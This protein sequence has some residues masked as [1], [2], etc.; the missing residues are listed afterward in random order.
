[1]PDGLI[2]IK[3]SRSNQ[4]D[5]RLNASSVT[6]PVT[7]EQAFRL[8]IEAVESVETLTNPYSPEFGNF[9]SVVT[10]ITTRSGQNKFHFEF[11]D[12]I[13][14]PRV[15]TGA[16]MGIESFTP[17]VSA[18]GSIVPGKLF[19]SQSLEYKYV[20]TRVPS[21][22]DLHNDTT[23]ESYN[24]FTQLDYDLNSFHRLSTKMSVAPEKL[25][26]LGLNTFNP[27]EV[28]H[29]FRQRGYFVAISE[30]SI[31]GQS[32]LESS[33]SVKSYDGDIWPRG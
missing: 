11:H 17:R 1:G 27:T 14:R 4:S 18:V 31:L 26:Y 16:I 28:T 25:G 19:Y 32:I 29:D 15:R 30:R 6:D 5:L 8:P 7:G 12:P 23:L 2:N 21:L 33:Y 10:P 24:S 22:P 9:S 3:G 20:R 13:P